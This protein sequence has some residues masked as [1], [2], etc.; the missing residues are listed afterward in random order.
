MASWR[1]LPLAVPCA[2]FLA[3]GGIPIDAVVLDSLMPGE[4]SA[5]LALPS[6]PLIMI[7]SSHDNMKFADDHGLQLLRR[8]F[9][10]AELLQAV[11]DAI[12]SGQFGWRDIQ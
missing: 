10:L 6:L 4:P 11:E 5:D 7:S 9:R 3:G 1:L 8:P 12:A 2:R